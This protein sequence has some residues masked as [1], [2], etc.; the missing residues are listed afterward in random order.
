MA[1]EHETKRDYDEN[2]RDTAK[3]VGAR[4]TDKKPEP[5]PKPKQ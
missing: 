1:S 2:V 4:V 5:Q 3:R